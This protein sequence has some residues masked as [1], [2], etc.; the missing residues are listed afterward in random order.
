MLLLFFNGERNL[1][2][3]G[4]ESAGIKILIQNRKARFHFHILEKFEAG[5]VLQGWEIKS[6]RAGRANLGEGY[7]RT[8]NDELYLLGVHISPYEYARLQEVNPL[9]ER[10]LLL[11]KT[12]IAKLSGRVRERGLTIIP[13]TI[14]L[15]RGL[16]KVEIALAQGKDAPDKREKIKEREA[17]REIQR[18]F[19]YKVSGDK[20]LARRK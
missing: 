20:N 16:A 1:A 10:K 2:K 8:F 13:L 18:A 17:N 14:Y 19:R 6:I 12:E 5:L 9:R 15:K 4:Q 7:V 3:A 11:H